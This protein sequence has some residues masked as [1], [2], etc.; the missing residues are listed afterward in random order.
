MTFLLR[1]CPAYDK[2]VVLHID[3]VGS[4]THTGEFV[5]VGKE[6]IRSSA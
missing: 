2:T 5:E 6:I 1:I 4:C 3:R